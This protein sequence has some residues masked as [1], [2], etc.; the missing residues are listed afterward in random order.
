LLRLVCWALY[1]DFSG[2]LDLLLCLHYVFF[3]GH[4]LAFA[5]I[6][7]NVS[8]RATKSIAGT[9]KSFNARNAAAG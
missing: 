3:F 2:H 6:G 1:W 5:D 4:A 8:G 7:C 9:G